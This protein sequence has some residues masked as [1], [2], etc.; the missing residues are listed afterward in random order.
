MRIILG[1]RG[2]VAITTI[3]LVLLN[4]LVVFWPS[5]SDMAD[6]C[7]VRSEGDWFYLYASVS[8][9]IDPLLGRWNSLTTTLA[10]AKLLN[11][12]VVLK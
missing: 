6:G 2:W 9:G 7:Y 5:G 8:G 1:I 4:A 3:A 10:G 11:C 12:P